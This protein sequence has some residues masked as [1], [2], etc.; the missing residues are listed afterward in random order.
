M[1]ARHLMLVMTHLP[2]SLTYYLKMRV[3]VSP[4]RCST[5]HVLTVL[6]NSCVIISTAG[7]TKY[8]MKV[9]Q[10]HSKIKNEKTRK[11][12][13]ELTERISKQTKQAVISAGLSKVTCTCGNGIEVWRLFRCPACLGYYCHDCYKEHFITLTYNTTLNSFTCCDWKAGR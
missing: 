4:L 9:Q 7:D 1:L 10:K 3:H 12:D 11:V 2:A 8:N 5:Q 13:D 6:F